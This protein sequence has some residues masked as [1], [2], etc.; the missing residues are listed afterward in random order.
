MLRVAVERKRAAC[1]YGRDLVVQ[2][3]GLLYKRILALFSH[4]WGFL[5]SRFFALSWVY[6]DSFAGRSLRG[7]SGSSWRSFDWHGLGGEG[8]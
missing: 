3:G 1:V 2:R 7:R 4:I 8:G 5:F 6:V